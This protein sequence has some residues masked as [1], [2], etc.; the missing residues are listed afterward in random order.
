MN[1]DT[2]TPKLRVS[3]RSAAGVTVVGGRDGDAEV[4]G[5]GEGAA[6]VIYGCFGLRRRINAAGDEF[7]GAEPG[8]GIPV[9]ERN[10]VGLLPERFFNR[11]LVLEQPVKAPHDGA[12]VT[13]RACAP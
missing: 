6:G 10:R 1:R 4:D 13:T 5:D 7:N 2:S 11:L 8:A 3:V 9:L 12:G